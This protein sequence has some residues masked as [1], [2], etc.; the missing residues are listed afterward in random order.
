MTLDLHSVVVRTHLSEAL[1]DISMSFA[2]LSL[3]SERLIFGHAKLPEFSFQ[4]L[5]RRRPTGTGTPSSDHLRMLQ[6]ALIF[7]QLEVSLLHGGEH[8]VFHYEYVVLE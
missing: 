2:D 8:K 4:T 5:R 1:A 7:G 3:K 6:L